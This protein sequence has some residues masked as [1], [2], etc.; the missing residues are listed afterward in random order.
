LVLKIYYHNTTTPQHHNTTTPQHLKSRWRQKFLWM[1]L[2]LTILSNQ[3]FSKIL[4]KNLEPGFL[5]ACPDDW[6]VC[7]D[8]IGTEGCEHTFAITF[9]GFPSTYAIS[10]LTT[11]FSITSG[12]G[13]ISSATFSNLTEEFATDGILNFSASTLS[14][15]FLD[16]SDPL[17]GLQVNGTKIF[18]T[19]SGNI[20][21]CFTL[22]REFTRH[23]EK[24]Y[25]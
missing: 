9:S 2:L 5:I 22:T 6:N 21:T 12:T 17:T 4:H 3:G 14:Y 10:A 20:G 25:L 23:F 7:I 16:F 15:N 13:V 8:L 11:S 1:F 18:F 24:Y 19:V